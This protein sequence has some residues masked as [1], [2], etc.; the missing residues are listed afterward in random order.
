MGTFMAETAI[1]IARGAAAIATNETACLMPLFM[2]LEVVLM[3]VIDLEWV[4][5]VLPLMYS[6]SRLQLQ[7]NSPN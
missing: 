2:V 1:K 3:F 6:P 7:S 5:E 4:E